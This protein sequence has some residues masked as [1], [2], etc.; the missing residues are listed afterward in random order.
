M[1]AL[2]QDLLNY[3]RVGTLANPF[4]PPDCN[5]V[6][7]QV[8]TNLGPAI[9]DAGARIQHGN[10]PIVHG[11]FNQIAQLVQNLVDNAIKYRGEKRPEVRVSAQSNDN[12]WQLSVSDNGIG[13]NQNMPFRW[14]TSFSAC[15]DCQNTPAPESG[16]PSAKRLLTGT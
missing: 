6:I 2:I 4:Q 10:P 3:S 16:S 11:D 14:S 1:Q 7:R 9:N 13:F 12:L 5:S 8:L 15:T